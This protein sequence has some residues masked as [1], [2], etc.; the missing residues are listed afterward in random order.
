MSA[1]LKVII[2]VAAIAIIGIGI[3]FWLRPTTLEEHAEIIAYAQLM[4]E[5]DTLYDYMAP[6]EAETIGLTKASFREAY[7]QVIEPRFRP[8]RHVLRHDVHLNGGGAQAYFEIS[9]QS[10][11]GAKFAIK[12]LPTL[13]DTGKGAY[14][15][16]NSFGHL[17]TAS[18]LADYARVR[19]GRPVDELEKC[20]LFI[21]K[22]D[23]DA[24]VL[25]R[26]GIQG[27]L[28]HTRVGREARDFKLLPWSEV[29]ERYA[30]RIK[31]LQQGAVE[32]QPTN[33]ELKR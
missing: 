10:K 8:F 22:L 30:K 2:A 16:P 33:D 32:P 13:A 14:L 26:L 29:R 1:R 6:K 12:A 18:W 23:Q 28:G 19:D 11:E 7:R 15:P 20:L 25:S 17:L 5:T 4:G 21:E 31:K 3:A 27:M 24:P 9:V